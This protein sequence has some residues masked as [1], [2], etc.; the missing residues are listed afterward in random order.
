MLQRLQFGRGPPRHLLVLCVI[1]LIAVGLRAL[2]LIHVNVN[3]AD[4]RF[5]DTVFYYKVAQSLA[6]SAGYLDPWSG[7]STAQWP[8]GYPAVLALAF[9]SLA[10][11]L[12]VAKATNVALALASVALTYFL[13]SNLFDKRV[14]LLAAFLLAVFPSYIYLSTLAL[15]ENLFVPAFLL[16]LVL[17]IVWG[18]LGSPPTALQTVVMGAAIGFA[19]LVR[20]E[21]LWLLGPAVIVWILASRNVARAVRNV[22]LLLVGFVLLLA[23]WTVRNVIQLDSF[24]VVRSGTSA[25]LGPSL[26]PNYQDYL[27]GS[28]GGAPKLID[29]L[30]IYQRKPW[31]AFELL[32]NKTSTLYENDHDLVWWFANG[33]PPTAQPSD[34]GIV[35]WFVGYVGFRPVEF[36][37]WADIADAAYYGF[38][39]AAFGGLAF[40]LLNRDRRTLFLPGIAI[41]WTLG[42]AFA[43]PTPRYHLALLPVLAIFAAL[44]IVRLLPRAVANSTLGRRRELVLAGTTLAV[45]VVLAASTVGG[46][47]KTW[48]DSYWTGPTPVPALP[49]QQRTLGTWLSANI[50]QGYTVGTYG[51]NTLPAYNGNVLDLPETNDTSYVLDGARPEIIIPDYAEP[52]PIIAGEWR[53]RSLEAVS[54][55]RSHKPPVVRARDL[56]LADPRLWERY[57][58][59]S[60]HI[61]GLWF[62]FLVRKDVVGNVDEHAHGLVGPRNYFAS[63]VNQSAP[64]WQSWQSLTSQTYRGLLVTSAAPA[65]SVTKAISTLI[66][67]AQAGQEF[68][69]FALVRATP[70]SVGDS[71]T[72]IVRESGGSTPPSETDATY[73]LN[74]GWLPLWVKHQVEQPDRTE[75]SMIILKPNPRG[76]PDSFS[77][78]WAEFHSVSQD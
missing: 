4:G 35:P 58:V 50:P 42:F 63:S 59:R 38:G 18:L 10:K 75:L 41:T 21:G 33:G 19:S 44:L 53:R 61:R 67:E 28:R 72:V 12:I 39:V 1:L 20:E 76:G 31:R 56:L 64:A 2:W 68:V 13:A 22:V 3:P 7:H 17:M 71:V 11:S 51:I 66:V 43:I 25:A 70:D 14:G 36:D 37:R 45:G 65:Y 6:T 32:S 48:G 74:S 73:T 23:P 57:E 15:S 29:D 54:R 52:G 78:G 46:G 27:L 30:R 9:V 8:P 62:N 40:S 24:T 47:Y 16:V 60:A 77:V 5:D 55:E 49:A 26:A 34:Q 69:A